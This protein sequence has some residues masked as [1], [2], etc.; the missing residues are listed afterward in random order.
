[1]LKEVSKDYIT[2]TNP[3][4]SFNISTGSDSNYY[5]LKLPYQITYEFCSGV[6]ESDYMNAITFSEDASFYARDSFYGHDR[7]FHD[8]PLHF[9][10]YY[11]IMVVLSGTVTQRIE[12]IDYKYPAGTCCLINRGIRHAENFDTEASILFVGLS[13]SMI[14]ELFTVAEHSS[15]RSEKDFMNSGLYKFIISDLDNPDRK[16]Y[17]DMIPVFHNS[18]GM[19]QLHKVTTEMLNTMMFPHFGS[20][21]K[22]RSLLS[23]LLY[24]IS[25]NDNYH[26][27]DVEM[28]MGNDQLLF[29]RIEHLMDERNGRISRAELEKALNYSGDYLNR[30]VNKYTG[31]CLY[32]YGMTFC[33][34]K[35]AKD[36][37]TTRTPIT[38]IAQNLQFSNRTHFYTLFEKQFHMTP[39]EYRIKMTK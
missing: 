35:A 14:G 1:M 7:A 8:H 34:K 6:E 33:L 28:G 29:S 36:L 3:N 26:C 31:M 21:Y 22:M 18:S 20:S 13:T 39:K 10:D 4:A 12:N 24:F 25:S 2:S 27:T 9:H 37:A 11:E 16:A 15:F 23:E 5:Q 30:I 17:L 38:S 32:D 19:E